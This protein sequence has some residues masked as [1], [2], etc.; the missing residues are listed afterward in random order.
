MS[1]QD[2]VDIFDI[3]DMFNEE[4]GYKGLDN[5]GKKTD[6][7]DDV[8]S[9]QTFNNW[10][11]EYNATHS[12]KIRSKKI[13]QYQNEWFKNDIEKL[14]KNKR[15]QKN[16]KLAYLRNTVPLFEGGE[17]IGFLSSRRVSKKYKKAQNELRERGNSEGL[18]KSMEI[19]INQLIDEVIENHFTVFF[20]SKQI[21]GKHYIN[22]SKIVEDFIDEKKIEEEAFKVIDN[23]YGIPEYDEKGDIIAVHHSQKRPSTDYFLKNIKDIKS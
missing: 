16:L 9:R 2:K 12:G 22:R 21:D 5:T 4:V 20:E 23:Y 17:S 18:D 13:N 3:L 11:K 1:N 7:R 14:I 6:E 8:I 15:V 19:T 10:L